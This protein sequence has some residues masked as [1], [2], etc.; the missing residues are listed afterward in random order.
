MSS[1]NKIILLFILFPISFFGFDITATPTPATC[2]GNGQIDITVSNTDPAGTITYFLFKLPD[3]TTPVAS[4]TTLNFSNLTAG[5]YYVVANQVVGTTVALQQV[6]VEILN[7]FIPLEVYGGDIVSTNIPCSTN[8]IMTITPTAGVAPFSYEI[9]SGP[10]TFPLQTSNTFNNL[11]VG[12]YTIRVWDACGN[13]ATQTYTVTSNSYTLT[14][15]A[16]VITHPTP[17]DCNSLI[18][19]N[20]ISASTGTA[21]AYPLAIQYTVHDPTTTSTTIINQTITSGNPDSVS[22]SQLIPAYINTPYTYDFVIVD[23]CGNV[24]TNTF[25]VTDDITFTY[26]INSNLDCI[27]FFTLTVDNF[28]SHYNLNFTSFPAGFDPTT[29]G[30]GYPGPYTQATTDFGSATNSVPYGNYEVTATDDCGRTKT[31]TFEIKEPEPSHTEALYNCLS[32]TGYFTLSMQGSTLVGAIIT[33]GPAGVFTYPYDISSQIINGTVTIDNLPIGTYI[34]QPYDNCPTLLDPVTITISQ[35]VDGGFAYSVRPG[36]DLGLTS[37]DVYSHNGVLTNAT[38]TAAPTAF[39]NQYTLPYDV[40]NYITQANG[41]LYLDNLP[42][43]N[44]TI[45]YTDSCQMTNTLTVPAIGYQITSNTVNIIYGCGNFDIALNYN[46][47]GNTSEKF[48]L[49]KLIDPANNTWG[50]PAYPTSG[51]IYTAGSIPTNSNSLLLANNA[52]NFNNSYNGT[53]RIIHSFYSYNNGQTINNGST[54]NKLC[55]EVIDTFS[56]NQALE[57]LD[58][59]RMP[60]STS[61]SLDVVV[62]ATGF[63]TIQYSLYDTNNNLLINN[64]SNNVFTNLTPGTYIIRIEDNCRILPQPMNVA[65]LASLIVATTP[66]DLLVCNSSDTFDLTTQTATILGT[67]NPSLYTVTYFETLANAQNNINPI[68]NPTNYHPTVAIQDIYARIIYNTLSNCFETVTFKVYVGQKPYLNI[69]S[70]YNSCSGAQV[71]VDASMG[72]PTTTTYIW[73]DTDTGLTIST[74]PTVTITQ[75]G[76]TNLSITATNTYG[77]AGHCDNTKNT[78]VT[79]S[80]APQ[81]DHIDIVDWTENDNSITVYTTS[82]LE[83]EYSLDGST[84]QTSNTF[85]GLEPGIYTVYVRDIWNCG[86]ISK[87]VALFYYQRFF[88]PNGDGA[89]DVWHIRYSQMEPAM[90][91][92]IFDRYGKLIKNFQGNNG[93]WDGTYNGEMLFSDDYWFLVKRADGREH[94]GHFAMKR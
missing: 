14:V 31:I 74:S 37:F 7:Q 75:V 94:R 49:Q 83:F 43:G 87:N 6:Q 25:T 38:I 84:W 16:P 44:Y 88:T 93:Y 70:S 73:I 2:A 35:F 48:W 65:D 67:Q 36:C 18:V 15:D 80:Q 64:G 52:T 47:N 29:F 62:V 78:S 76:T 11:P 63:G 34:V 20:T 41:Y 55:F 51:S 32:T 33:S 81:F 46:T 42:G 86:T 85:T 17:I 66:G 21:I 57:I 13:G 23:N 27:R 3:T 22:I 1:K 9:V 10:L 58:I 28:V 8:S 40:T 68:T 90:N 53:F 79:L 69:N 82:N 26:N 60:C 5:T 4:T 56:Y 61:G 12:T 50:H 45:T 30:T 91:I 19:T 89:N 24:F 59:Y 77:T 92:F 54:A 71:V 72:N 39:S